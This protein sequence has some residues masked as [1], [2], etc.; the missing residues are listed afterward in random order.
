VITV[1]WPDPPELTMPLPHD[2]TNC[3]ITPEPAAD[4]L[5]TAL[6]DVVW[7]GM[8]HDDPTPTEAQ[9]TTRRLLYRLAHPDHRGLLVRWLASVGVGLADPS[10]HDA[11]VAG[12]IDAG[13][14]VEAGVWDRPEVDEDAMNEA[15]DR[16]YRESDQRLA[17]EAAGRPWTDEEVD[18]MLARSWEW[19][20]RQRI[21]EGPTVY[22][23]GDD[24]PEGA[25]PLYLVNPGRV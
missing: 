15:K 1:Q 7:T 5:A 19:F 14:L 22:F 23:E 21:L 9:Q 16:Y 8:A 3:E 25:P 4:E 6:T 24:I 13:V 2:L 17:D 10:N 12:L 18:A 11:L 20:D